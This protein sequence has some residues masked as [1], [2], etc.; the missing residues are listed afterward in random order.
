M[1]PLKRAASWLPGLSGFARL[2]LPAALPLAMLLA[3]VVTQALS[4]DRAARPETLFLALWAAAVFVPLALLDSASGP[5]HVALSLATAAATATLPR[6]GG[7]RPVV[8]AAMLALTVAILAALAL[9]RQPAP[10]LRTTAA[11]CLAGAFVL[12]GHRL[13]V[14]GLSLPALALLAL[15]PAIAA[16]VAA[17]LTAAGRPG[18]ALTAAIA[19]VAAPQLASEPWWSLLAFATAASAACLGAAGNARLA[20]R[21]LLLY[22]AATLVA[23]SFPWLRPAPVATLLGTLA[24]LDRPVAETP[25]ADRAVVLTREAPTFEAELAGTAVRGLVLDSYLT[26]GVD[27]PCGRALATI[28]LR[29]AAS[30]ADPRRPADASWSADL[31]AGRDSA[32]WAAGRPDVAAGLACPA[33]APWISWIP[34]SGR[35]LGQTTRARFALPGAL[36]AR[37]LRIERNPGLPDGTTVAIFFAATER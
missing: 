35:F 24:K 18:A 4:A 5:V 29:A 16:V 25:L 28:E 11:L 13:F 33:P 9:G 19:L 20:Q 17:R 7:L 12:Q 36:P 32:E 15:L 27:L 6:T 30:G 21:G 37:H 31:V 26:H 10:G 23:G 1:P 3:A 22:F 2:A 34:G 14:A 8:V